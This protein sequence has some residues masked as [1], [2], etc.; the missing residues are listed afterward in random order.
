MYAVTEPLVPPHSSLTEATSQ[1][2]GEEEYT[3]SGTLTNWSKNNDVMM[4]SSFN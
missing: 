1:D 4:M 2:I 3:H